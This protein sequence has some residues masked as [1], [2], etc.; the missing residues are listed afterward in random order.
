MIGTL[1]YLRLTSLRNL[2]IQRIRRLR[3][4][5]YLIGT[6]VAVGYFYFFLVRR[7]GAMG[8]SSAMAAN[9]AA[10][11]GSVAAA[12]VCSGACLV[13]L[14]RIAYAWIAPAEKPGLRFSEAEIA[15]LFPAPITRKALI[16]FRLLSSQLAILFTSALIAVF[17]NRSSYLGGSRVIQAVG[18]WVILS[19]FDL[20]LNGTNLTLSRLRERSSHFRLWRLAAVAA[21][22]LYAGAVIESAMGRVNLYLSGAGGARVEP[23]VFLRQLMASPAFH[24]LTL[25]LRIVLAPYFATGFREFAVAIVPALLFMALHYLWVCNTEA[26]FEEGSIALAE[27]RA[28]VRAAALRG[29]APK[30]GNARPAARSGPF[31]LAERG[32]PEVAFL[33]KNLLSMRSSLFSRRALVVVLVLTVWAVSFLGP[34]LSRRSRSPGGDA[35][36]VIIVTA[37]CFIA[38]YTVLLGPQVA[39]QDLRG[40]LANADILKTYPLEGWRLALGEMLAPAAIL[41]LVL[42]LTIAAA[43]TAT[44]PSGQIEWL[45][46]GVRLTIG[47]CL[48]CAAPLLCLTQLIV[49]NTI[50]VLF[51]GWY[52]TART[53]TGGIEVF[54]QRLIFGILQLFFALLAAVPAGGWAALFIFASHPLLGAGPAVVLGTL[55][56]LFILGAEAAVGLWWLGERFERFD[57]ST[58]SR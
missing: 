37:S 29:E 17:F 36:G 20:H 40:D 32:P 34:L 3:Q 31:P 30:I 58:E 16:H 25:P 53:R 15:F 52:Q 8:P 28:A 54:G 22:V 56:V 11:A 12:F 26:H 35:Y 7:S 57:L 4:P 23:A 10:G 44:D 33:W 50:M 13:A 55:V 48:A 27:K 46:P 38:A 18:W 14:I 1:L 47:L 6:A 2:V 49:P 43:V 21:I 42:W 41:T 9:A 45:T 39:R 24:W 51:P 5:K 19:T